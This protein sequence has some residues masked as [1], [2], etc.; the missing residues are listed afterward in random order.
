MCKE[1]SDK[2]GKNNFI[3]DKW[4]ETTERDGSKYMRFSGDIVTY[5]DNHLIDKKQDIPQGDIFSERY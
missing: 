3:A 4:R 1:F 2:T 5:P